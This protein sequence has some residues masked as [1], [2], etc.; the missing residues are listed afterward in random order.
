VTL[1]VRRRKDALIHSGRNTRIKHLAP[2]NITTAKVICLALLFSPL[3]GFWWFNIDPELW[4]GWGQKFVLQ[5]WANY[6]LKSIVVAI[7][8]TSVCV[9][10]L[11]G[12]VIVTFIR[13]AVIRV[14]Y[15]LLM[16]IGW[17]FELFVLDLTGSLSNQDLLWILW[18]EW[19]SGPEAVS[20]YAP[21]IIR[22]C[23][24]V[25]VLGAVLCA[26]PARRFSVSGI[27]GLL[28]IVSLAAVI[29]VISYT[30]GGTQVFPIPFG[31]FSNV[32][33]VLV[34]ALDSP[35]PAAKSAFW[36]PAQVRDVTMSAPIKTE[37]AV[38]PIY[39]KIVMI[40]DE[41]VRGDYVSLND[42][43]HNTTTFLKTTADLINFG[44][45]ISGGNC[46]HLSRTIFR[47]GMRRSELPN[48]W[49]EGLKK[50]TIWQFAHAAGYKTVHIDAAYHRFDNDLAPVEKTLI[51]FNGTMFE[52]PGYLRD[53]KL[54][55]M[56]ILALKD[57]GPAFI[58]VDKYGVHFPY[59]TKYPPD[60]HTFPNPVKANNSN[61][62]NVTTSSVEAFIEALLPPEGIAQHDRE[63]PR[64]PDAIAWSVDGFFRKL[65]PSVDL[66]KTLIIYTAFVPLFAL[67]SLTGF[68]QRLERGADIGFDRF[69]HFEVFPTLLLAMGYDEGWVNRAYG[70]S[71][72]DSP[73]PD[74][75]FMIGSPGFHPMMI[76]TD[77]NSGPASSSEPQPAGRSA[78]N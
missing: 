66:S 3:W 15:V 78:L 35:R 70:P 26:S 40:M 77:R 24:V 18:Q 7:V 13:P 54:I 46:S 27:F 2:F 56:L 28:P 67:T 10:A 61:H 59:S 64:Y 39:N 22:N 31:T 17:A 32:G 71:L 63:I 76:S 9:L 36:D 75:A 14:P 51:D 11:V 55:D 4:A 42:E 43:A 19:A 73:S 47:F 20:G 58:Y 72:M 69:S 38:Q 68:K 33:V 34:R 5:L 37:G 49:G 41:S 30:K 29:G 45:A 52:N 60:F 62:R 53:H 6:L 25:M 1:H 48:S 74:R 12:F 21:Y 44:V 8:Y 16:L 65:L 23:A 50:P 57:E